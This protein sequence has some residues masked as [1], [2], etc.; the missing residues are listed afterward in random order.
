MTMTIERID[1]LLD[2]GF[3]GMH[4]DG[5]AF[6]PFGLEGRLRAGL[7]QSGYNALIAHAEHDRHKNEQFWIDRFASLYEKLAGTDKEGGK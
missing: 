1:E 5:G 2:R 3:E 7:Y 4:V 6:A